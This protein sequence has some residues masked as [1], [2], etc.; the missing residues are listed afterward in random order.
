MATVS[1]QRGGTVLRVPVERMGE[2]GAQG[3]TDQGDLVKEANAKEG[4]GTGFEGAAAA[5]ARPVMPEYQNLLGP[6]GLL[7]EQFQIKKGADIK[8]TLDTSA[9]TKLR[10][11]AIAAPGTSLWEKLQKGRQDIVS[12]DA[13]D[14]GVRGADAQRLSGMSQLASSGGLTNSARERL[15]RGAGS[16]LSSGKQEMA[17][18]DAAARLGIETTAEQNRINLLSAQP[19]QELG[20]ANYDTS[21]GLSN[22]DYA[23]GIDT[24]NIGA[25]LERTKLQDLGKFGNYQEQMRGWAAGK[26]ADATASSGGK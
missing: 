19:N 22:R 25:A 10:G 24:K 3:W 21:L 1:L 13:R 11:E 2:Y 16:D 15:I 8:S 9:L 14:K 7:K 6:T 17:R 18:Q 4:V 23:T 26:Q 20:A 5:N 12:A